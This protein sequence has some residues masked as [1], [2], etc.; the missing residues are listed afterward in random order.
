MVQSDVAATLTGSTLSS[1]STSDAMPTAAPWTVRSWSDPWPLLGLKQQALL[2]EDY[3]ATT[4][5][6]DAIAAG[7]PVQQAPLWAE[8]GRL[9][10]AALHKRATTAGADVARL[11]VAE[12]GDKPKQSVTAL[13]LELEAIPVGRFVYHELFYLATSTIFYS[14]KRGLLYTV[15]L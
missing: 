6:R 11:E 9:K 5:L 15:R 2:R 7:R 8:L 14:I 4:R 13:I 1:S 12:D 10:P 3:E